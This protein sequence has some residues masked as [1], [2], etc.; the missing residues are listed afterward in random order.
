MTLKNIL[1][2]LVLAAPLLG[3]NEGRK[4]YGQEQPLFL[5]GARRQA[6][7]VAPVINLS[8][9][10]QVDPL[11]QA[12]LLYQQLQQVQGVTAIPVNRVAEVYAKLRIEK[13]ESEE[14]A[15]LVCNLL[16][17]D[18]LVVGTVTLYDPYNPP[19]VGASLQVLR[20]GDFSR[21]ANVDVRD[22]AR[23]ASP[24]ENASLPKRGSFV[25][26]AGMFDS[27]N[28]SVRARLF[29]YA[30]GRNDPVGPYGEMEYLMDA[31]RYCGFVYFALLEE[32]LQKPQLARE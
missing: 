4:P 22:L 21:A 12:D 28:G 3:C 16:G 19:K 25:Q 14:Q 32:L 30:G 31:D 26:V 17:C 13:V 15:A 2:A 24:D 18:G 27:A 23:R 5:P 11:L 10:R 7:A 29:H 9:Q 1:V 8:G 20:P 6:W